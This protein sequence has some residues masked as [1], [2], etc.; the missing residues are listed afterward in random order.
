MSKA[1][2]K[3]TDTTPRYSWTMEEVR[4]MSRV[5]AMRRPVAL[6]AFVDQIHRVDRLG[7][8]RGGARP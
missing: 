8:P 3:K 1:T 6:L 2:A 7:C 5:A 4:E